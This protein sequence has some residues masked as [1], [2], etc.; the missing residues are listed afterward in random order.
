[1]LLLI[2]GIAMSDPWVG[3]GDQKDVRQVL[4]AKGLP[5]FFAKSIDARGDLLVCEGLELFD[6]AT[7][8]AAEKLR[9]RVLLY[10]E[11]W[12]GLW[13]WAAHSDLK[14]RRATPLLGLEGPGMKVKVGDVVPTR[15]KEPS[16][17]VNPAEVSAV[18]VGKGGTVVRTTK[19]TVR[20]LRWKD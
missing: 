15:T 10:C 11:P 16:K 20:E 6:P 3:A 18:V 14:M 1:M 17:L 8:N 9:G 5:T 2:I 12:D 7:K 19:V 13:L 4:K